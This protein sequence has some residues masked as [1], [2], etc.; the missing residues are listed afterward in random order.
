MLEELNKVI[1]LLNGLKVDCD[2]GFVLYCC[3][4]S[5]KKIAEQ[6]KKGEEDEPINNEPDA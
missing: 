1:C 6:L 3:R 2:T 4:N 5:L